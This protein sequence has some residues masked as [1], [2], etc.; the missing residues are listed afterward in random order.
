M[1]HATMC[2]YYAEKQTSKF[3]RNSQFAKDKTSSENN[4]SSHGNKHPDVNKSTESNKFEKSN[5]PRPYAIAIDGHAGSGKG[6]IAKFLANQLGFVHVDSGL[7]YRYIAYCKINNMA[8]D[9]I[10]AMECAPTSDVQ[11]NILEPVA[12]GSEAFWGPVDCGSET[13]V[14]GARS[15]MEKADDCAS[16]AQVGMTDELVFARLIAFFEPI[17]HYLNTKEDPE[18]II[19]SIRTEACASV[20]SRIS[21]NPR[22]R[23]CVNKA[24]RLFQGNVVIDGRGV[25]SELY[26]DADVKLFITASI[27]VRAHR[28]MLETC[29][30]DTRSDLNDSSDIL[31]KEYAQAI[32]QRDQNDAQR[33]LAPSVMTSDMIQLDTSLDSVDEMCNKA[34]EIV[35][36]RLGMCGVS[37]KGQD[38]YD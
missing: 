3:S 23:L 34:L 27:E 22:I 30:M 32:R 38:K 36:S 6:T 10:R 33:A 12:C 8:A 19:P 4:K 37:S 7:F 29:I 16:E 35:R 18:S 28:R 25:A 15:D 14:L 24:I 13:D 2:A 1:E 21:Q 26:P 31:L 20:A 11:T 5:M 9:M 17:L